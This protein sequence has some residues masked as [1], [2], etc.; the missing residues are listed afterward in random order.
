MGLGVVHQLGRM[1][2]A[3][4]TGCN[5]SGFG[6]GAGTAQGFRPGLRTNAPSGAKNSSKI[7]TVFFAD[8]T[9]RRKTGIFSVAWPSWANTPAVWPGVESSKPRLRGDGVPGFRRLNPMRKT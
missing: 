2:L 4:P 9:N 5:W 8:Q 7:K 3:N 1:E 6:V